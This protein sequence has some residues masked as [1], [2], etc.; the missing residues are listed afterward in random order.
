MY[1]HEVAKIEGP[2]PSD[3]KCVPLTEE[4]LMVP[5]AFMKGFRC[6]CEI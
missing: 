4:E 3:C 2:K 6:K 5:G 1:L